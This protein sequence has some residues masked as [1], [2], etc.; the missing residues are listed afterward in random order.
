MDQQ[1]PSAPSS[2]L[3]TGTRR[4]IAAGITRRSGDRTLTV[5]ITEAGVT[6]TIAARPT[7]AERLAELHRQCAEDYASN[8]T[9]RSY[10]H[11]DDAFLTAG[12]AEAVNGR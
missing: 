9:R 6:G 2:A 5:R 10:D 8:A 1:N 11:R 4:L 12:A 7:P 3:I